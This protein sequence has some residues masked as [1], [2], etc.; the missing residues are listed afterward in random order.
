MYGL[1]VETHGCEYDHNLFLLYLPY[2]LRRQ[3]W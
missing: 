2:Q 1:T 3:L